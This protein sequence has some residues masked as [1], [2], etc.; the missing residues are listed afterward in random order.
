MSGAPY[1]S[2]ENSPSFAFRCPCCGEG[3]AISDVGLSDALRYLRGSD[4]RF[5]SERAVLLGVLGILFDNAGVDCIAGKAAPIKL[6][7]PSVPRSR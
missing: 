7:K 4:F 3:V 6:A 1:R 2:K 5:D